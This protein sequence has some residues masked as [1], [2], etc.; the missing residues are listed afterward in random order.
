[1]AWRRA[2]RIRM[3]VA[4]AVLAVVATWG[5]GRAVLGKPSTV[6]RYIVIDGD[7][8]LSWPKSCIFTKVNLG[9]TTQRLRLE[10]I[11]AFERRQTCHDALDVVWTCGQA[12]TERLF[13]L[14]IRPDFHC[15]IDPEF[16]D[17]H[18]REFSVCFADGRDVGATLVR[19]GLAFAYGRDTSYLPIEN[20]A[21]AARRGAW[22]GTFVRPQYFREG[23]AG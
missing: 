17:R 10:G 16:I 14:V 7:T 8:F 11:D 3:I 21:K 19:E 20:E 13:Q 15:R 1:M 5:V 4:L 6:D 2:T 22:A 23:A 9:C 18:A 12:A